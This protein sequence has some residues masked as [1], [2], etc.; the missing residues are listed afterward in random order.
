MKTKSI[1]AFVIFTAVM[2]IAHYSDRHELVGAASHAIIVQTPSNAAKL[3]SLPEEKVTP[4]RKGVMSH[5]EKERGKLFPQHRTGRK[6]DNLIV[7]GTGEVV[8]TSFTPKPFITGNTQ[9]P[10]YPR[11]YFR[12]IANEADAIIIGSVR[13]KVYSQL[14]NNGEFVFSD[15]L[16]TV[17]K[18]LKDSTSMQIGADMTVSRPG[19]AIEINNRIIRGRAGNFKPFR[20]NESY[21]LFLKYI[22]ATSSYVAFGNGSYHLRDSRAFNLL[23]ASGVSQDG[24]D[25]ATL[26]NHIKAAISAGP[27][28]RTPSLY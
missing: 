26:I 3:E 22:P 23:N 5:Q 27:C 13:D 1:I 24:D 6:I 10:N 8:I 11:P 4:V 28:G 16:V 2:L 18:V 12:N 14:T 19:G 7:A 15:Y 17:Q 25:A 9:C 20:L 21:I